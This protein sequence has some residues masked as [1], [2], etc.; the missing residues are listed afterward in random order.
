MSKFTS[1]EIETMM[2]FLTLEVNRTNSSPISDVHVYNPLGYSGQRNL[3]VS[4][5]NCFKWLLEEVHAYVVIFSCNHV[6]VIEIKESNWIDQILNTEVKNL[7]FLIT[8]KKV[9]YNKE[10]SPKND[11]LVSLYKELGF[12]EESVENI[13]SKIKEYHV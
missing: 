2:Q 10:G 3:Q 12:T 4:E 8:S 9:F 5:M 6:P 11:L 13:I 7:Q 1:E